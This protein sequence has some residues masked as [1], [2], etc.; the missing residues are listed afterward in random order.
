VGEPVT[1]VIRVGVSS[2]G[3]RREPRNTSRL[4][5]ASVGVETGT[6]GAGWAGSPA[7][8][9]ASEVPFGS[10]M[11]VSNGLRARPSWVYVS[12]NRPGFRPPWFPLWRP[13]ATKAR[14]G[15]FVTEQSLLPL[16]SRR[17][18]RGRKHKRWSQKEYNQ[19]QLTCQ[20]AVS[21]LVSR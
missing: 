8:C 1:R 10:A 13:L 18:K 17:D 2:L 3:S 21:E 12:A 9:G 14:W 16:E 5:T 11:H 4:V 6:A 20:L 19:R 7:F 15:S